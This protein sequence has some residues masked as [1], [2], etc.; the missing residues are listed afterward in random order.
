MAYEDFDDTIENIFKYA[1]LLEVR[2]TNRSKNEQIN[3]EIYVNKDI[4]KK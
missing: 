4:G 3:N 1:V 2:E